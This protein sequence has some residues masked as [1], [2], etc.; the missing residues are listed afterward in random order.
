MTKLPS[1]DPFLFLWGQKGNGGEV[2]PHKTT[3]RVR[4]AR[5]ETLFCLRWRGFSVWLLVIFQISR[6]QSAC[7]AMMSPSFH[8]G[9]NPC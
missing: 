1:I 7:A 2:S 4:G 5:V 8:A 3:R 6:L 9:G